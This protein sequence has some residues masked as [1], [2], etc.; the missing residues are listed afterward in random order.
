ML[1]VSVVKGA[2]VFWYWSN[3]CATAMKIFRWGRAWKA[4]LR[5]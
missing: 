2:I 4:F 5:I 3:A 1:T